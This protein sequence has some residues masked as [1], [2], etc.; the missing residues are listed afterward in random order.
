MIAIA[1]LVSQGFLPHTALQE[2]S[3]CIHGCRQFLLSISTSVTWRYRSRAHYAADRDQCTQCSETLRKSMNMT[4]MLTLI[5]KSEGDRPAYLDSTRPSP[6]DVTKA[7]TATQALRLLC[8]NSVDYHFVTVDVHNILA[9]ASSLFD[10]LIS[11]QIGGS[12]IIQHLLDC[13]LEAACAK[14]AVVAVG[15]KCATERTILPDT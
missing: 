11:F 7:S 10:L 4:L 8:R 14:L 1:R 12:H 3:T 9:H 6:E 13:G 2:I 5:S 15:S